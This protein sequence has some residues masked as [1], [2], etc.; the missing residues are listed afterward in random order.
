[1]NAGRPHRAGRQKKGRS[2]RGIGANSRG[3]GSLSAH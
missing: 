1:M 3:S 2:I